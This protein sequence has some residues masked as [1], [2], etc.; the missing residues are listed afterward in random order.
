MKWVSVVLAIAL[1]AVVGAVTS[2]ASVGSAG[3]QTRPF[4]GQVVT[5]LGGET[6]PEMV[7]TINASLDAFE[8]TSGMTVVYT[9]ALDPAGQLALQI[10]AGTRPDLALVDTAQM[11]TLSADGLLAIV[12]ALF[13]QEAPTQYPSDLLDLARRAGILY[14]VPVDVDITSSV[15]YKPSIFDANGYAV[16]LLWDGLTSLS[17]RMI[18]DGN[19]PFCLGVNSAT[20]PG[21]VLTDWIEDVL[22]RL[23]RDG[24]LVT[25]G[26]EIYDGWAAHE[27]AFSDPRVV[28]AF[29]EVLELW[30]TAGFTRR[31]IPGILADDEVVEPAE[32]LSANEC[33]MVKQG[34]ALAGS[35]TAAAANDVD[36]FPLP[37]GIGEDRLIVDA[38]WAV[39][40]TSRAATQEALAYLGS[41]EYGLRRAQA[42]RATF[43]ALSGFVSPRVE[44]RF[45]PTHPAERSMAEALHTA[46]LIRSDAS[47]HMDPEV[48]ELFRQEALAMLSGKPIADVV[49]AIDAVLPP[50][51]IPL[52]CAGLEPTIMGTDGDDVLTGTLGN[53]V[54]YAGDGDDVVVG[55]GGNDVIC[56]GLGNDTIWGNS[57]DDLIRGDEG[58]DKLRGGPGADEVHG[59]A[60]ACAA[61]SVTTS[62]PAARATTYWSTATAALMR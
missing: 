23:D 9:P 30:S 13:A 51:E 2:A 54:I 35:L 7:A 8:L 10:E 33:A 56:G 17:N 29:E 61:A 15:W 62:C 48:A 3:A 39:G 11:Q 59:G 25:D 5:I 12:P 49:A 60:G 36:V 42:Q 41:T 40:L 43:G 22:L 34:V 47:D 18:N 19:S 37:T 1:F 16:P 4:E 57:G 24:D 32:G 27:I 46:D 50:I 53:D 6:S 26:P 52:I 44:L 14:G 31:G 45:S 38:T 55:G 20:A 28:A 21:D 58:D